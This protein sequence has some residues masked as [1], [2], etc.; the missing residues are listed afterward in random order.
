[1]STN[2]QPVEK[3]QLRLLQGIL[4]WNNSTLGSDIA[5]GIV[6]AALGI[7]EVMGYTKIS[8][9]PIATGLYTLLLP[10]VAFAIFGSSRHLVVAADSATAAIIAAGLSVLA[11]AGSDRYLALAEVVAIVTAGL[12]LLARIF[13]L[14]FLADFLSRTVLIGF[15]TG[16]G[17]Q[18][19][20]GQLGE[21]VGLTG[22]GKEPISQILYIGQHLAQ[23]NLFTLG[24]SAAVLAIVFLFEKFLP[25]TSRCA[26]GSNRRD[27]RQL[28]V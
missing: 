20:I 11:Q 1:M 6:L 14:G 10:V 28:A 3:S 23:I 15:L 2:K 9:T 7:P 8:G 24:I 16:V 25:Q 26:A 18:V 13:G 5:A 27:C 22:G 4:P 12:L 19:A 17:I 21:L